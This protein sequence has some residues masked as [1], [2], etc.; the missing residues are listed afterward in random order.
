[1]IILGDQFSRNM[2]RDTPNAFAADTIAVNLTLEGIETGVDRQLRMVERVFFCKPCMHSESREIQKRSIE[3]FSDL[4]DEASD[5]DRSIYQGNLKF[6]RQHQDIIEKFGRFPH[7]N[8]I[9]GRE[10]T[11]EEQAFLKTPGS[12]F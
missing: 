4:V 5:E 10:S 12:S 6:A 2:Y 8:E 9:L 7:R 11:A 3:V 1:M